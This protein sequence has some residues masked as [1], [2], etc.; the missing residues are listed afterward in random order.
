MSWIHRKPSRPRMT[1]PFAS[2]GVFPSSLR[3]SPVRVPESS[4]VSCSDVQD[5]IRFPGLRIRCPVYRRGRPC[6]LPLPHEAETELGFAWTPSG[7]KREKLQNFSAHR[8]RC[9]GLLLPVA[10]LFRLVANRRLAP[11]FKC[12]A[13]TLHGQ[14]DLFG[15]KASSAN[16]S[17]R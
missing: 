9:S 15:T 8:T 16:V 11:V 4:E 17:A 2:G 12:L 13:R 6:W 14:V 1:S 5:P 10:P 7:Q 3:T